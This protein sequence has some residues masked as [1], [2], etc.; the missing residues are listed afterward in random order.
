MKALKDTFSDRQAAAAE[1]KRKM[2]ERFKPK[3]AVTAEQPIDRTAQKE[4]ELAVVRAARA[5][6]KEARREAQAAKEELR[7]Q[8]IADA[9]QAVLEAKRQERKDRKALEKMDAQQRRAAKLEAYSRMGAER[10]QFQD[11]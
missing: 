5:A 9:E 6:E 7:L 1:A 8:A 11:A 3:P 2:M 4:A 10:R